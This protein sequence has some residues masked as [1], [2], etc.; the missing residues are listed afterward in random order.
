[1]DKQRGEGERRGGGRRKE[2]GSSRGRSSP[3]EGGGAGQGTFVIVRVGACGQWWGAGHRFLI[4]VVVVVVGAHGG[5]GCTRCH[6]CGCSWTMVASP[7]KGGGAGRPH[8]RACGRSSMV[9]GCWSPFVDHGHGGR[10]W[11]AL[12]GGHR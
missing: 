8:Y 11:V 5:A 2:I 6:A 9:V 7:C 12:G 10:S 4:M 3:S 1:M